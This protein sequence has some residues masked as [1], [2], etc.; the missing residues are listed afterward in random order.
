MKRQKY[1]S[2]NINLN[3]KKRKVKAQICSS[4]LSKFRGM[5][6]RASKTE[7]L[8]FILDREQKVNLHMF[9]VFFPIYAVWLD[10]N[11]KQVAIKKIIAFHYFSGDQGKICF[12]DSCY[13]V[14][15]KTK[16][17]DTYFLLSLF[18]KSLYSFSISSIIA[19]IS[20]LFW[21]F[22]NAL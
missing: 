1:I 11:K 8:F 16:S 14:T 15:T 19:L 10:R 17:V 6:F 4:L 12:G 5:M 20:P 13:Q 7:P 3:G 22:F 18:L 21:Y 2:L 9:F